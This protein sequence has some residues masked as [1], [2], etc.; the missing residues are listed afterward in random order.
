MVD[1]ETQKLLAFIQSQ[2]IELPENL[3]PEKVW[4]C[5]FQPVRNDVDMPINTSI[6]K[7]WF[8]DDRGMQERNTNEFSRFAAAHID[9]PWNAG[10][11]PQLPHPR[12]PLFFSGH[13][14]EFGLVSFAKYQNADS[15]YLQLV[16][17]KLH[18]RGYVVQLESEK[19]I[20]TQELWKS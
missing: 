17:G 5:S 19:F 18:G 15:Y 2:W 14:F 1:S 16:W 13:T 4:I 3:R 20:I 11:F 9:N 10:E 7:A 12:S 8:L 6:Q